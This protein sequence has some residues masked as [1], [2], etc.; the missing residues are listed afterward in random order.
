[1]ATEVCGIDELKVFKINRLNLK[2]KSKDSIKKLTVTPMYW[3]V[4]KVAMMLKY[5]TIDKEDIR[6]K[7]DFIKKEPKQ[8]VQAYYDQMENLFTRGKLEEVEQKRRFTS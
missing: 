4:V 2:G 8:K 3:Q 5:G 6:A 1:M 7:L